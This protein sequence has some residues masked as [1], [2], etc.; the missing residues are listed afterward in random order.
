MGFD[1]AHGLDH[2]RICIVWMIL[3]NEDMDVI[4]HDDEAVWPMTTSSELCLTKP[5]YA[6]EHNITID[7]L[8]KQMMFLVGAERYEIQ[9]GEP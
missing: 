6:G 9:S 1:G 5:P 2:I 4:G 8:S 7:N 3:L